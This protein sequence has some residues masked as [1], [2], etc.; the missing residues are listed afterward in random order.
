M[1]YLKSKKSFLPFLILLFAVVSLLSAGC[2]K[3]NFK[4]LN[5]KAYL[6]KDSVYEF[7]AEFDKDTLYY[8][9]KD[10]RRPFF[11]RSKFKV[12]KIDDTT[13]SLT[14]EKKPQFWTKDTWDIIVKENEKGFRSKESGNYY[15]LYVDSLIV[16]YVF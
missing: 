1:N 10:E 6:Y 8:I 16:K 15:N 5:G 14:L 4:R 3:N 2:S 7:T 11:H 13:F 9:M 12:K